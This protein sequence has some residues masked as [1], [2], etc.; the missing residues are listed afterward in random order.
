M[1]PGTNSSSGFPDSGLNL[2]RA[3]TFLLDNWKADR[4]NSG[5][6]LSGTIYVLVVSEQGTRTE[7]LPL[8]E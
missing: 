5:N 7:L 2:L 3:E 6:E 4:I 1:R 8:Y